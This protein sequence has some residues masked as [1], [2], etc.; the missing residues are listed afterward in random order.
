MRC[1]SYTKAPAVTRQRMY[2]DTMQEIYGNAVKVM[3]DARSGS[4]LLMLP[5]DKLLQQASQ[6][7]ARVAAQAAS[8]SA[9][10]TTTG[11][12]TPAS[13]SAD[14]DRG[15]DGLRSRDRESR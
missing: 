7:S 2:L 11:A 5:L 1:S 12:S 6:E 15:R 4:N 3:V 9:P 8:A 14:I 13:G 10:S